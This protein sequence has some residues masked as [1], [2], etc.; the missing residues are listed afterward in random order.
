M[1]EPLVRHAVR[2]LFTALLLAAVVV[3]G[4]VPFGSPS[5]E[6]VLRLALRT[7]E[8]RIEV[9]RELSAAELEALPRHMR[10][11]RTC[12]EQAVDYRLRLEVE[13]EPLLEEI[14]SPGGLRRDRPLIVDR[15]FV[16]EPGSPHLLVRLE[17]LEPESLD[18]AS[19]ASFA[20]LPRYELDQ[21]LALEPDRITLITVDD[22]NGGLSVMSGE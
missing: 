19:R 20:A 7:V 3:L 22:R 11:A 16:L 5:G 1:S 17:P 14:V 4:Q 10:Q 13:G 2:A 21:R 9:C 15:R 6:A 12:D 8:T 18:D